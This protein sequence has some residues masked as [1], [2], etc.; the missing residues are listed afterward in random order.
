MDTPLTDACL[1]E[2]YNPSDLLTDEVL[3]PPDLLD[4]PNGEI[5]TLRSNTRLTP[6]SHF[7]DVRHLVL[8]SRSELKYQPGD[9]VTIY[10]KNFPADVDA[11]I[12]LQ[13]WES[14]ADLPLTI[15]DNPAHSNSTSPTFLPSLLDLPLP[16]PSPPTLRRLLLHS[17]DITAIPR[18]H[19]FTLSAH[20][21]DS[22]THRERLLEFANPAH[23]DEFFDYTTRPRRSILEILHDFPTIRIPW[24][25][26][27][28]LLPRLRGRQ[29]SISSGGALAHPHAEKQKET[30]IHITVALVKYRT[31]LRKVR[32]GVCSRYLATLRPGTRLVMRLTRGSFDSAALL[33]RPLLLVAPG[34]GVAPMRALL[35]QRAALPAAQRARAVLLFGGR[36]RAADF[37]YGEEWGPMGVQ[38]MTAFSRDQREKVYV[39]DVIRR[40]GA[41][42]WGV[43]RPGRRGESGERIAGE[44]VEEGGDGAV[45]VCGSSG[46]MP[47]AVRK[48]LVDVFRAEGGMGEEEAE[49]VLE[50]MERRGRYVQETW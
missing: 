8:H 46:K 19:F 23:T 3:P 45:V 33:R 26:A 48:A 38:V 16:T 28:A 4:I 10:P 44:A 18:R 7:Q 21:C 31:V 11:L 15:V 12:T 37:L 20:F 9:I 39:Q 30:D 40:E 35:H 49:R 25:D 13:G 6:T 1:Q 5:V 34:T 14:V 32:Q 36:S 2:P 24:T 22:P 29:F 47:V 17:L 27:L 50:G 41:T 43:L 42:V